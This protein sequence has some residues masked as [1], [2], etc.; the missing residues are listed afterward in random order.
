MYNECIVSFHNN[1]LRVTQFRVLRFYTIT[2]MNNQSKLMK[3]DHFMFNFQNNIDTSP[4]CGGLH[5]L[6]IG[7]IH[8]SIVSVT[9]V[10]VYSM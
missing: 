5:C 9:A 6:S 3:T 4:Y 7:M 10:F 8:F 2:S 1:F